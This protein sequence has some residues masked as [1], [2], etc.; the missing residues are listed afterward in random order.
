LDSSTR[1]TEVRLK[2]DEARA[3]VHG[4]D[5]HGDRVETEVSLTHHQVEGLRG[6]AQVEVQ[7]P[8]GKTSGK[9]TPAQDSWEFVWLV[10]LISTAAASVVAGV[11][12]VWVRG[13]GKASASDGERSAPA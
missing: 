2:L 12:I 10:G 9:M 5:R 7:F 4:I 11:V 6:G 8:D 1:V 3:I 13:R